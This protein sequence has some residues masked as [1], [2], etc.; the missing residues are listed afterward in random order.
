MPLADNKTKLS[1]EILSVAGPYYPELGPLVSCTVHI[2]NDLKPSTVSFEKLSSGWSKGNP[3]VINQSEGQ[4][5]LRLIREGYKG[6]GL[7]C[8]WDSELYEGNSWFSELL[9][10]EMFQ[11][12]DSTSTIAVTLPNIAFDE[13]TT[14]FSIRLE[15]PEGEYEPKLGERHIIYIKVIHDVDAPT[16]NFTNDKLV[17]KQ[18]DVIT[19]VR[20]KRIGPAS[21]PVE[22]FV[23]SNIAGKGRHDVKSPSEWTSNPNSPVSPTAEDPFDRKYK[24]KF[25]V[26]ETEK[27]ITVDLPQYPRMTEK[28]EIDLK[29]VA[30]KPTPGVKIGKHNLCKL[31]VINDFPKP[32][33]RLEVV[34]SYSK[35]K[36][37]HKNFKLGV[38]LENNIF[39]DR[40]NQ[41]LIISWEIQDKEDATKDT[42]L[43]NEDSGELIFK[44][45]ETQY[46]DLEFLQSPY[47]TVKEQTLKLSVLFDPDMPENLKNL[48]IGIPQPKIIG[49]DSHL[50]MIENDIQKQK[51]GFEENQI[52]RKTSAEE[53]IIIP[54]VRES[55]GTGSA[56]IKWETT[57]KNQVVSGTVEFDTESQQQQIRIPADLAEKHCTT[58]VEEH[59]VSATASTAKL[60]DESLKTVRKQTKIVKKTKFEKYSEL[61]V[62]VTHISGEHDPE[63]TESKMKV[64]I[65][66]DQQLI[67]T[68]SWAEEEF[69]IRQSAEK[70]MAPVIRRFGDPEIEIS[71]VWTV[72]AETGKNSEYRG[73]YGNVMLEKDQEATHA[74]INLAKTAQDNKMDKFELRLS[75]LK[76]TGKYD[77]ELGQFPNMKITVLNDLDRSVISW[78]KES[79]EFN[80]ATAENIELVMLRTASN[81]H[82]VEVQWMLEPENLDFVGSEEWE[83]SG[84]YAVQ[85][86]EL[87]E[88]MDRQKIISIPIPDHPT[89]KVDN[90]VFKIIR[91]KALDDDNQHVHTREPLLGEI[92]CS[93]VTVINNISDP[94]FE[95][96]CDSATLKNGVVEFSMIREGY[97]PSDCEI[98]FEFY[99][100]SGDQK[101]LLVRS[102]RFFLVPHLRTQFSLSKNNC[103]RLFPLLKSFIPVEKFFD[104][105]NKKALCFIKVPENS[106]SQF[107]LQLK[108]SNLPEVLIGK[109]KRLIV[110]KP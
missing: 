91:V 43:L 40:V 49:P 27:V 22:C 77:A 51:F 62:K 16:I 21:L 66:Q 58:Q 9:G 86:E 81:I 103:F 72:F 26:Q 87:F 48:M 53:D 52:K 7:C 17:C 37:S 94:T 12:G 73:H 105:S 28:E 8:S 63:F 56:E 84:Y 71:A 107:V 79:Y 67:P 93:Q 10:L 100:K 60:N 101:M 64:A 97:L 11:A 74:Q 23:R 61:E 13:K 88:Y 76:S 50:I 35:V 32:Q 45:N 108:S 96:G 4:I 89:R 38:T 95:L 75:D 18:S 90:L 99:E 6:T 55:V 92:T 3:Y 109:N 57:I 5:K 104:A 25:K 59:F 65:E 82:K 39:L 24:L 80:R 70:L 85:G 110:S 78:E 36:R 44:R 34:D 83:S 30:V 98:N 33:I 2:D 19:D 47:E 69:E 54:I 15:D 41:D 46:I 42:T 1:L 68:L 14:L 106:A 20:L 31:E 102:L 29:I